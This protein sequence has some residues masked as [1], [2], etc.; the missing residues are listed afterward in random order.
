LISARV[1][2]Q[3]VLEAG[4]GLDDKECGL[5]RKREKEEEEGGT[6]ALFL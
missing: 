3:N 4:T 6:A 1:N 5:G 2:G